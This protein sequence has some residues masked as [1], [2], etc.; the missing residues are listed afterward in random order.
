MKKEN[1]LLLVDDDILFSKSLVGSSSPDCSYDVANKFEEAVGKIKSR[2]YDAYILDIDL[3]SSQDGFFLGD[4]IKS[5]NPEAPII[6]ISSSSE[7]KAL[8]KTLEH[9]F[10]HFFKK[11]IDSFKLAKK[12]EEIL[13]TSDYKKQ[14]L[15]VDFK[16]F[17]IITENKVMLEVLSSAIN[18][19]GSTNVLIEGENGTGKE[20]TAKYLGSILA[21]NGPFVVVNCPAIPHTLMESIL[22]GHVKGAF[23]GAGKDATGKF[24]EANGGVIFLDEIS[25]ASIDLQKK[26]LRVIQNQEIEKVGTAK[27]IGC[28]VKIITS[29]NEN[30]QNKILKNEFRED[31]FYRLKRHT[32]T[33]PP[34]RDR[35]DDIEPLIKHFAG[36]KKNKFT[37]EVIAVLKSYSWPGNIRELENLVYDLLVKTESRN[38]IILKDVLFL[39]TTNLTKSVTETNEE[40]LI[41]YLTEKAEKNGLLNYLKILEQQI[42]TNELQHCKNRSECAHKLKIDLSGLSKRIKNY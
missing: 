5:R 41:D 37:R 18:L 23:T 1:K 28:N 11:S 17:G 22:F 2:K 16:N 24:E 25:C 31:L 36:D 12:I 8:A 29:T 39:F 6:I 19:K 42:I 7:S 30:L 38:K 13:V 35:I 32:F 20:A 14:N 15:N 40:R 10:D 3:N 33:L 34:L 26:L 27:R 21:P 4:F 9:R